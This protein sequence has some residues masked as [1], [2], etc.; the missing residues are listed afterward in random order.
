M[1]SLKGLRMREVRAMIR[2]GWRL[3][4]FSILMILVG[5]PAQGASP[6]PAGPSELLSWTQ[7]NVDGFGSPASNT[8]WSMVVFQNQLY[9][10]AR[11][12]LGGARVWRR[13]GDTLLWVNYAP[14][15]WVSTTNNFAIPAMLEHED[16]SLVIGSANDD[17]AEVWQYDGVSWWPL[18]SP[19]FGD[20]NNTIVWTLY[21]WTGS[22][23]VAGTGNSAGA[24]VYWHQTGTTWLQIN[25]DGFG[26]PNNVIAASMAEMNDM[27]LVV[28]TWNAATGG[29]VWRRDGGNWSQ[30]NPNG[31][32]SS[33]NLAARSMTLF[34]DWLYV[35]TYNSATGAE[36]W[37]NNQTNNVWQRVADGGFDS[38]YNVGVSALYAF[39]GYLFAGTENNNSGAQIWRSGDGVNWETVMTGGF[40]DPNNN[41]VPSLVGFGHQLFAGTRN[42]VSG[43]E[44]WRGLPLGENPAFQ[45]SF[46]LED[47][48]SQA[49]AFNSNAGEYLLGWVVRKTYSDD[50]VFRRL[51]DAGEFIG[52]PHVVASFGS[53]GGEFYS[54]LFTAYDSHNIRYMTVW[55][56]RDWEPGGEVYRLQAQ[57]I[58]DEGTALGGPITLRNVDPALSGLELK[59]L[60]YS[61][62]SWDYVLLYA[63]T[64]PDG[65]GFR[66]V[67]MVIDNSGQLDTDEIQVRSFD[68]NALLRG[69][70][71]AW[72]HAHNECLAVWSETGDGDS[73]VFAR[74]IELATP[75]VLDNQFTVSTGRDDYFDDYPSVAA[76]GAQP[77]GT[78]A[79]LVA[80]GSYLNNIPGYQMNPDILGR[81]VDGNGNLM[82]ETFP[83]S[84]LPAMQHSPRLAASEDV[85]A[86]LAVYL[87]DFGGYWDWPFHHGRFLP[88]VAGSVGRQRWLGGGASIFTRGFALPVAGGGGDFLVTRV[89]RAPNQSYTQVWATL[90]H[91]EPQ[92]YLPLLRK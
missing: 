21:P 20:V 35:G 39:D 64:D 1:K 55:K 87:S 42:M 36:I 24:Q 31:F 72:N 15:S 29:E 57:L 60:V 91:I 54:D 40:G 61:P 47:V 86:F 43:G 8:I 66:L 71:L 33:N 46:E 11:N 45:V 73:E 3:S 19:G 14:P 75:D 89:L 65:T 34:K 49:A 62:V 82:G 41:E 83:I 44:V 74:I 27:D 78:G 37:R 52:T 68:Q 28:G 76:I 38:P 81:K 48:R 92:V 12:P 5:L 80:W 23:I 63:L 79:Y 77:P 58:S 26:D 70:D 69:A 32:D 25:T 88:N 6:A 22:Y 4:L 56:L 84:A 13:D 18:N 67:A 85:Q 50:V 30:I 9:A 51:N 2:R 10:G 59:G 16:G 90:S 17:G 7:V 53:T